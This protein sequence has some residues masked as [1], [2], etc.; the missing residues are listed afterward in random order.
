M[1]IICQEFNT[2]ANKH[3]REINHRPGEM[4]QLPS[5]DSPPHLYL[6]SICHPLV[7]AHIAARYPKN[8][9]ED[10]ISKT[11]PKT[12]LRA[13]PGFAA[14]ALHWASENTAPRQPCIE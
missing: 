14:L 2:R 9:S 13:E 12:R 7:D 10:S 3:D 1:K 11:L 5:T 8:P 6:K 4:L